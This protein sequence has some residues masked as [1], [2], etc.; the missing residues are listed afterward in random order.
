M[1]PHAT[2]PFLIDDHRRGGLSPAARFGVSVG[3][4]ALLF[5][6]CALVFWLSKREPDCFCGWSV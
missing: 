5:G 1:A 6:T 2:Q 3:V 4:V